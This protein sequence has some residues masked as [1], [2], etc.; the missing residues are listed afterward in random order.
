MD[1]RLFYFIGNSDFWIRGKRSPADRTYVRS[2]GEWTFV[3]FFERYALVVVIEFQELHFV[4]TFRAIQRVIAEGEENGG[5]PL[6]E[7]AIN[8]VFFFRNDTV[9]F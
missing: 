4:I 6:S 7:T 3:H 9:Q 5:P 1:F 2:T 8:P